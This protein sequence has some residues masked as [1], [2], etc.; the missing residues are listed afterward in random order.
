MAFAIKKRRFPNNPYLVSP[1]FRDDNTNDLTKCIIS[2][3]YILG[4]HA[5]R[6]ANTGRNLNG[7][8]IY[9]NG[10]NGTA[11]VHAIRNGRALMIEVKCK[12]TNDRQS[13]AQRTYQ[14]K[15]E[16]AGGVYLIVRDF[17]DFYNYI[18]R[19]ANEKERKIF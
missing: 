13:N 18:K 14:K 17:K 1:K 3:C 8:W 9:S 10:M 16:R 4:I 2:F 11:D 5:E 6:V 19:T 12:Y 15:V 7:K